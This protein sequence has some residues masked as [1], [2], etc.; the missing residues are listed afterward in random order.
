[1]M[2]RNRASS[3]TGRWS[4]DG[5]PLT[6]EYSPSVMEGIR[7][8]VV[9]GY[10]RLA[11]G[12]IEVGGVLFGT[13]SGKRTQ[14]QA[15]RPLESEYAKGPSFVLSEK[16]RQTLIKLLEDAARDPELKGMVPV[17]WYHSHTRSGI[18]LSDEDHA[19]YDLYFPE[20]S[21]VALVL[22]PERMKPVR[23]GFFVRETDGTVRK[24]S[25]YEEF[26]VEPLGKKRAAADGGEP[27]EGDVAAAEHAARVERGRTYRWADWLLFTVALLLLLAG[28]FMAVRPYVPPGFLPELLAPPPSL[29]PEIEAHRKRIDELSRE[30]SELRAHS[31]KQGG[32]I[33]ELESRIEDLQTRLPN[34]RTP[35]R[36]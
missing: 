15:F 13:K 11:R 9:E 19:I 3:E 23:A 31:E 22:R 5:H 8:A 34:R 6:I 21:Q 20:P 33:R 27:A 17:G 25:S 12:G 18:F 4:T 10:Y 2:R 30:L 36:R 26:I 28:I 24:E 35:A 7:S 14:I 29:S 32:R 16:D 1:M